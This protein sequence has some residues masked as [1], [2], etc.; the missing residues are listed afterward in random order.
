MWLRSE[1]EQSASTPLLEA[2]F[3]KGEDVRTEISAKFTRVSAAETFEE[4]GLELLE[5]YT[6]DGELFSLA[7]GAPA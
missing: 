6:D 3:E 1:E 7:L 5:L 4:A 2:R